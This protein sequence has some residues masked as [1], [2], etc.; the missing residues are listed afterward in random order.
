MA[1]PFENLL[2]ASQFAIQTRANYDQMAERRRENTMNLMQRRSEMEQQ[3]QQFLTEVNLKDRQM[4]MQAEQF[5]ATTAMQYAFE[6][7]RDNRAGQLYELQKRGQEFEMGEKFEFEKQKAASEEEYKNSMLAIAQ[8]QYGMAKTKFDMELD[9]LKRAEEA[10]KAGPVTFDVDAGLDLAS[11]YKNVSGKIGG[12]ATGITMGYATGGLAGIPGGVISGMQLARSVSTKGK[13]QGFQAELLSEDLVKEANV[14]KQ[15]VNKAIYEGRP[16][17][18]N[19]LY[20]KYSQMSTAYEE[21]KGSMKQREKLRTEAALNEIFS[22]LS[23]D[24]Q[25]RLLTLPQK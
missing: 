3:K 14:I 15:S 25:Q 1:S 8:G 7:N 6:R 24:I 11:G 5:D 20:I 2:Q 18:Q 10:R 9:A 23:P 21:A 12:L 13:Q 19:Q 4:K 17:D 22:A 16:I